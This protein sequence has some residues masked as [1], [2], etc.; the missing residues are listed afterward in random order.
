MD[1]SWDW[2]QRYAASTDLFGA[3][4]PSPLLVAHRHLLT[5]GSA[6]LAVGD[7]EGRNGVWLAAQGLEV[8]SVDISPTALAR[9]R[10][11]AR[12]QGLA[13]EAR[14]VDI[15]EWDWPVAAFD[16]VV[17]I[18]VHLPEGERRRVHRAMAAALRPGGYLMLECF[19]R[20]QLDRDTGGPPYPELLYSEEELRQD[21]ADMEI[22]RL[23]QVETEVRKEGEYLGQGA[24]VHL[25][26]RKV[27]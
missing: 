3:S 9:A 5:P 20:D 27:R 23:R 26:G 22:L 7:G 10:A 4:P 11:L 17:Y 21:F 6:A 2:E 12:A 1:N 15:L 19:H 25:V 14:E 13:L 16:L 18:F 24:A 8:L